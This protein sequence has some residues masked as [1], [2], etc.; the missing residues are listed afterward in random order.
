MFASTPVGFKDAPVTKYLMVFTTIVPLV[1]SL[2]EVHYLLDLQLTPHLLQWHQYWRI[3]VNQMVYLGQGQVL[4]SLLLL[5]NLRVVERLVGSRKYFSFIILVYI[6]STIVLMGL[7]YGLY[8][9]PFINWNKVTPG[10]TSVLFGLLLLYY[11][12]VP[13]VYKFQVSTGLSGGKLLFSDKVFV[14]GVGLQLALGSLPGSL[15][16]G[17]VGWVIAA[18]IHNE[19]IPGK[20]WRIS[21][22]R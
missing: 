3:P 9:V 16:C 15:I 13:V 10:Q 6:E 17:L 20:R 8:F 21:G 22:F 7:L 2:L 18:L 4:L 11:Y 14:Y 5:Y 19:V 1:V 12:L